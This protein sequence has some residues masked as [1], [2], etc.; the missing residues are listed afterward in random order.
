[1]PNMNFLT[2]CFKICDFE[3]NL[4]KI[5]SS[6]SLDPHYGGGGMVALNDFWSGKRTEKSDPPQLKFDKYSPAPFP[7][8]CTLYVKYELSTGGSVLTHL[9]AGDP[10]TQDHKIWPQE[11]RSID[12]SIVWL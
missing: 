5:S 12:R 4:P 9:F 2:F 8:Y 6:N 11:T 3:N 7:S 1:M 10:Q